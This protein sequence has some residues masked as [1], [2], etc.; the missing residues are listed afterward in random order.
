MKPQTKLANLII[1]PMTMYK[2]H[3]ALAAALAILP[4]MATAAQYPI[5]YPLDAKIEIERASW[6]ERVCLYV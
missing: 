4:L 5:N 3:A 1:N 6:R 2:K